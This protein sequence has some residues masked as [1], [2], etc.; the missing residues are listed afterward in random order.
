[1]SLRLRLIWRSSCCRWCR[2]AAV[3]LYAYTSNVE[4]LREPA[5]REAELLAGELSQ[6]MQVVTAQLTERVEHLMDLAEAAAAVDTAVESGQAQTSAAV[7]S[8]VATSATSAS[9]TL[10]DCDAA[11]NVELRDGFR[12]RRGGGVAV[13]LPGAVNGARG[14]SGVG[15][16]PPRGGPLPPQPPVPPPAPSAP[17]VI[18]DAAT[19]AGARRCAPTTGDCRSREDGPPPARGSR[20]PRTG[21]REY[22]ARWHRTRIAGHTAEFPGAPELPRA[23]SV[24]PHQHRLMPIGVTSWSM[25]A[26]QEELP[27]CRPPSRSD[28]WRGL[29]AD[30]PYPDGDPHGGRRSPAADCGRVAGG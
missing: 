4:A 26:S 20:R 16:D 14:R 22:G 28:S 25:Y 11:S 24:R 2:L 17:A 1:M 6:R 12:G 3:T 18:A 29:A 27:N 19:G 13:D 23:G 8:T 30:A 5:G 21:S 10:A 7:S 15:S 9:E